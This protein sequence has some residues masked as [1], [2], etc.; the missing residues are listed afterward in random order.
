[1]TQVLFDDYGPQ[2]HAILKEMIHALYADDSKGEDGHGA[3]DEHIERTIQQAQKHPD[4]LQIKIFRMGGTV[5]GYALL[6]NYWSNER[7][8]LV[9]ILDE[10]YVLPDHRGKGISSRFL[11][12]LFARPDLALIHLE[13]YPAN[14]AAH[15][16]YERVGFQAFDRIHMLRV[17]VAQQER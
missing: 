7:G 8:G 6:T 15:K 17:Q 13:V 3:S 11:K 9:L 2:D 1:M 4:R 12:A 10:M 14:T 5:A 16:L